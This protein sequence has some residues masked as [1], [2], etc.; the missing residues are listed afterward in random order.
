MKNY[1]RILQLKDFSNPEEIKTAYRN[2][3]R[4]IHPDKH[5]D[6]AYFT[7]KFK[8]LQEAYSHLS[9]NQ[10]RGAYDKQLNNYYT[11]KEENNPQNYAKEQE[12]LKRYQHYTEK[13]LLENALAFSMLSIFLL[14]YS[15]IGVTVVKTIMRKNIGRHAINVNLLWVSAIACGLLAAIIYLLSRGVQD[16]KTHYEFMANALGYAI[17]AL[18]LLQKGYKVKN[19]GPDNDYEGDSIIGNEYVNLR[20]PFYVIGTGIC[21]F[22]SGGYFFG[23]G[24][25]YC[26][27]SMCLRQIAVFM[28]KQSKLMGKAA[29]QAKK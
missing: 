21:A 22:A 5:G 26:G 29:E 9:D 8:D 10:T 4:K 23:I 12:K 28:L 16:S 20:E 17:L 3:S 19:V 6:H 1:Y 14:L 18:A 11:R 25:I 13:E 7:E 24:I 15:F 2:I 27:A